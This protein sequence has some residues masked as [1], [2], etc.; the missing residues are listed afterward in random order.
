MVLVDNAAYSYGFQ[1]DNGIPII[2]YYEGKEDCELLMLKYYLSK[3]KTAEDVR[4]INRETFRLRNYP[5]YDSDDIDEL[6][7]NLY[8]KSKKWDIIFLLCIVFISRYYNWFIGKKPELISSII[9]I[10]LVI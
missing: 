6:V 9:E 7:S 5:E 1:I 2:P 4:D 3:L 8:L 10:I